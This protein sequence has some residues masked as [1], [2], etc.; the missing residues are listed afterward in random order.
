M[1]HSHYH[2]DVSHLKTIDIYRIFQL[3]DVT[4]PCAQH[5]IKKLMCAGERGVKTEEQDIRE[6]HDTLARRLQMSAEDD[7]ALE[8][9]E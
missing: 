6:A 2:R 5:A 9:A 4:D 8:G 1:K 3:Y 7:T